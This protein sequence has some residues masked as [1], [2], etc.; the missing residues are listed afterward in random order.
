M[1]VAAPFTGK[2]SEMGKKAN[3]LLEQASRAPTRIS[4]VS[5]RP[6]LGPSA[7]SQKAAGRL[8]LA[9]G[10]GTLVCTKGRWPKKV[11]VKSKAKIQSMVCDYCGSDAHVT[12]YRNCT[13]FC[14]VCQAEGHCRYERMPE[15]RVYQV[16]TGHIARQCTFGD[17]CKV[18]HARGA[19]ICAKY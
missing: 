15:A 7:G 5:R 16:R 6:L 10:S 18:H 1:K 19:C 12:G 11:K 3:A 8:A 17:Q 2:Q 14:A 4:G 9:A 13:R